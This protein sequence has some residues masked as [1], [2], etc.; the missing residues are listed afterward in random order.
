MLPRENTVSSDSL[1]SWEQPKIGR[2]DMAKKSFVTFAQNVVQE[3]AG[4]IVDM[5]KAGYEGAK[6]LAGDA[7]TSTTKTAKTLIGK[8]KRKAAGKSKSPVKKAAALK[9]AVTKQS[10]KNVTTKGSTKAAKKKSTVKKSAKRK[11]PDK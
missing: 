4:K 2:S 3:Q 5:A 10:P 1:S 7:V 11:A 9:K 6:S 8:P